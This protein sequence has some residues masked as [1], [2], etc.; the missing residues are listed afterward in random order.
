MG[1]EWRTIHHNFFIDNYSPQENVDNDDGSAYFETH[2]NFLVYGFTGQKNDYGGHDNHHECN[3]YAY[4]NQP[5]GI[6]C[7]QLDGHENHF[8]HNKAVVESDK[9]GSLICDGPGKTILNNNQYFTPSGDIQECDM[10]LKDWQDKGNDLNSTVARIPKD[11]VIIG[12]A[13]DLLEF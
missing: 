3:I 9:V 1:A 4:V 11:E 8:V 10:S 6:I 12:W 5:L 13:R 2:D 7:Q